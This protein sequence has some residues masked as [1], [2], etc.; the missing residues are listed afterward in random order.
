VEWRLGCDGRAFVQESAS[1]KLYRWR[2]HCASGLANLD[3][4][5]VL[6]KFSSTD[7]ILFDHAVYTSTHHRDVVDK[8]A[9]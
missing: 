1:S 2:W 3:T 5:D 4:F 7:C 8:L 9:L 6:G